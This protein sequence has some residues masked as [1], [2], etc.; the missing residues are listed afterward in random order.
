M[1]FSQT[2]TFRLLIFIYI[3]L[4]G[5]HLVM[6]LRYYFYLSFI[7]LCILE[8]ICLSTGV[9]FNSVRHSKL[10]YCS[11]LFPLVLLGLLIVFIVKFFKSRS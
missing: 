5:V 3:V 7:I 2:I 11:L 9:P 6:F 10:V 8:L 1:Y 4:R